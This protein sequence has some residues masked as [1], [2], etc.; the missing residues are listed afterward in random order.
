MKMLTKMHS[1]L[2]C[3]FRECFAII[4]TAYS[5]IAIIREHMTR[6]PAAENLTVDYTPDRWRLYLNGNTQERLIVEAAPGRSLRYASGFA[7]RRR[8]PTGT[9]PAAAVKQVVLGWSIS[10]QAW[11]LGLVLMPELAEKRGS[12]WCEIA[13]WNDPDGNEFA[14]Q[15]EVAARGLSNSLQRPFRLIPPTVEREVIAPQV[16]ELPA[17]PLKCGIWKVERNGERLEFVRTQ[18]WMVSRVFRVLWY[19]FWAVVYIVLSVAT[20]TTELALPNSG[21]MLPNPE[22]L[23]LLGLAAAVVLVL[24]IIK[25]LFDILT[26]PGKIVADPVTRT[27]TALRGST[28]RWQVDADDI[29]SIYVTQVAGKRGRKR[30]VY[31]GELNLQVGDKKFRNVIVQDQEE[32]RLEKQEKD[33]RLKEEITILDPNKVDTDLQAA[34]VYLAKTLGDLP[35]YYDQRVQ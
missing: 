28:R 20:L 33:E 3:T 1:N 15:A 23:P 35:C 21:T 19:S 4:N 27:V 30:T 7:E 6:I 10:D 26:Q 16:R 8:L 13:R 5:G 17:L 31:H 29:L 25:N 2:T 9:L 18:R 32:E 24:I 34:G 11:H 14:A 22:I 12:R